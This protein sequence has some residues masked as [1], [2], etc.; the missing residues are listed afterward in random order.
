MFKCFT[1][2]SSWALS[3]SSIVAQPSLHNI[4]MATNVCPVLSCSS[5]NHTKSG[6]PLQY[7]AYIRR[8]E[9]GVLKRKKKQTNNQKPNKQ[10]WSLA[11][12]YPHCPTDSTEQVLQV[13]D[14]THLLQ[15]AELCLLFPSF[16][17][18]FLALFFIFFLLLSILLLSIIFLPC[19]Y[20]LQLSSDS[21][22]WVWNCCPSPVKF[23][24]LSV[25]A[26]KW[27]V[28]KTWSPKASLLAYHRSDF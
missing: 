9:I 6:L 5:S 17:P 15:T 28:M 22:L 24:V 13:F 12:T 21:L 7:S 4:G 19:L 1:A 27:N 10:F 26:A 11:F 18:S 25:L 16:L 14:L 2:R 20:P 23:A 3:P 8:T